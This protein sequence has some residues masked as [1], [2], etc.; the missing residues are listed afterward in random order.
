M[1]IVSQTAVGVVMGGDSKKQTKELSVSEQVATFI[2][3]PFQE[4]SPDNN[5]SGIELPGGIKL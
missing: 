4:I 2:N 1:K 5:S 3:V